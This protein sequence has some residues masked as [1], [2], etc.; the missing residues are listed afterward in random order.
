MQQ[1]NKKEEKERGKL[2]FSWLHQPAIPFH[3]YVYKRERHYIYLPSPYPTTSLH[4]NPRAGGSC[5]SCS[6]SALYAIKLCQ[7]V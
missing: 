7:L 4:K 6:L 1:I 5:Q 2:V 3:H